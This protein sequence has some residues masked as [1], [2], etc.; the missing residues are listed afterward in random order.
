MSR[1]VGKGTVI[2]ARDRIGVGTGSKIAEYVT[3]RDADH[4]RSVPLSHL[5]FRQKPVTIG[6][7]VWVAAQAIVLS[8]VSIGDCATVAAGAVVTRDV[9]PG[10]T[11]AGVPAKPI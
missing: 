1:F 2:V 4:D 7:K 3:I 9:S 5:A 11:V 10:T 8:G 6:R